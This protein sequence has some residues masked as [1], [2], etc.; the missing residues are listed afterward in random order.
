MRHHLLDRDARLTFTRLYNEVVELRGNRDPAK[1]AFP[2]LLAHEA[3]DA[4]V[5]DA[6]GWTW[7]M[8]DDEIL[9][10]LL[11]LDLERSRAEGVGA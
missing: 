5:A 8:R 7:P 10:R 4:A 2:L 11:D 3:L 6:Y 9:Q 1:R